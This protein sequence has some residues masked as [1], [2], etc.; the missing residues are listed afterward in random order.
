VPGKHGRGP[1]LLGGGQCKKSQ[2][3]P[4]VQM[5]ATGVELPPGFPSETSV[6]GTEA[7][8]DL[9]RVVAAWGRLT[10]GQRAAV[11]AIVEQ[12]EARSGR[13]MP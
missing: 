10:K 8:S 6:L 5:G 3:L 12:A 1:R 2:V 4:A 7:N 11:L 9:R 13:V